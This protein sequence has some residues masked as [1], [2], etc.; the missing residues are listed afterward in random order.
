MA[1]RRALS[2][3]RLAKRSAVRKGVLGGERAWLVAAAVL[4]GPKLLQRIGGRTEQ[5]VTLER[6]EPGQGVV[7]QT[8]PQRTRAE[9]RALRAQRKG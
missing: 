1:L 8:L 5:V 2:P 6:L 3:V 7:L 4:Y 9:R